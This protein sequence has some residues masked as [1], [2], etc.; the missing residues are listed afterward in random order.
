MSLTK[1]NQLYTLLQ[2][3]ASLRLVLVG[4]PFR[5]RFRST[6]LFSTNT[7]IRHYASKPKRKG[8]CSKIAGFAVPDYSQTLGLLDLSHEELVKRVS[9]PSFSHLALDHGLRL[10]F[11]NNPRMCDATM[12]FYRLPKNTRIPEVVILGRSNV[13]KSSF[14]NALA[15]SFRST[16]ASTSKKAGRTKTLRMY[17][18]GPRPSLKDLVS[19]A[20]DTE[21][22]EKLPDHSLYIV[23][24]PGYGQN[25]LALWGDHIKLYL[26]KRKMLKGAVVLIDSVVGPKSTDEQLFRLLCSLELKTSIVLTKADHAGLWINRP[27][28]T[29]R[30]VRE[31][32]RK[33]QNENVH[34]NWPV[35]NI[36]YLTASD[37]KDTE[38]LHSTLL[39]TRLVIARQG[40]FIE[41]TIADTDSNKKWSGEVV[42][43]ENLQYKTNDI[44]PNVPEPKT[45][46]ISLKI[47]KIQTAPAPASVLASAPTPTL[48][49]ASMD[50]VLD[51]KVSSN[52]FS[53]ADLELASALS[54][55]KERQQSRSPWMSRRK[56]HTS[57][58]LGRYYTTNKPVRSHGT[59]DLFDSFIDDLK[60]GTTRS[61]YARN[62]RNNYDQEQLEPVRLQHFSRREMK[63]QR[64][65][66]ARFPDQA[67]R[68]NELK[69]RRLGLENEDE[70]HQARTSPSKSPV[71]TGRNRRGKSRNAS[72]DDFELEDW[73][74]L[75]PMKPR[76]RAIDAIA[77]S[78]PISSKVFN[79]LMNGTDS[80]LDIMKKEAK[81]K[82]EER[83]ETNKKKRKEKGKQEKRKEKKEAK[84][85]KSKKPPE[86]VDPFLAKF[87]AAFTPGK[88]KVVGKSSF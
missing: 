88:K 86:P 9:L 72:D 44:T 68:A 65:L 1:A 81:A 18:L 43:F 2:M 22:N 27:R 31:L 66:F 12:D 16:L 47:R 40:G 54:A 62:V 63:R 78:D 82:Q 28:N 8:D 53:F 4:A 46:S 83:R 70:R 58:R 3:P 21:D 48:T 71:E 64:K 56:F 14:I 76:F 51:R 10:F 59:Q 85:A 49:P 32:I 57:T 36:M 15:H 26:E 80:V 69:A 73:P 11:S 7:N 23:D 30:K 20:A 61:N 55:R 19:I 5:S 37:A 67:E 41:E 50:P 29:V 6:N 38:L 33:I 24:T 17:G 52:T 77:P 60:S 42:S 84:I 74:K 35:E 87:N 45:E 25:S 39:S 75:P 34:K 13:G 79:D